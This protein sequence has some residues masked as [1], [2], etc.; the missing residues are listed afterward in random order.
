MC[1]Y[2][3]QNS[4][5]DYGSTNQ[6][7]LKLNENYHQ[8]ILKQ[9]FGKWAQKI[10]N[11]WEGCTRAIIYL[12]IYLNWLFDKTPS[13]QNIRNRIPHQH[14]NIKQEQRQSKEDTKKITMSA[15]ESLLTVWGRHAV[16]KVRVRLTLTEGLPKVQ[17]GAC[18]KDVGRS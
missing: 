6:R 3:S 11:V 13:I 10:E 4:Q 17:G 8:D 16:A 18:T 2:S 9:S 5:D 15:S 7:R 1:F 12:N 14:N